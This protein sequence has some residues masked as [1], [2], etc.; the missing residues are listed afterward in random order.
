MKD[1][2]AGLIPM[3]RLFYQALVICCSSSAQAFAGR[4]CPEPAAHVPDNVAPGPQHQQLEGPS[5]VAGCGSHPRQLW[6]SDWACQ[7]WPGRC[8][9]QQ[10]AWAWQ[11]L[12]VHP[13]TC[14][15][16]WHH[17]LVLAVYVSCKQLLHEALQLG[18]LPLL[19]RRMSQASGGHQCL[20]GQS[21]AAPNQAKSSV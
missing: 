10:C 21:A 9:C 18:G 14:C 1:A 2:A 5:A 11:H 6:T 13:Y 19:M 16:P 3:A 20:V 15:F 17:N 8:A 12:F 7:D 4:L